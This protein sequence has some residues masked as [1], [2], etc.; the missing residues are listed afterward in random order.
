MTAPEQPRAELEHQ[1][2][3]A[4]TS[5]LSADVIV[6][7]RDV[8]GRAGGPASPRGGG[9]PTVQYPLG[10][11]YPG[12]RPTSPAC[13]SSSSTRPTRRWPAASVTTRAGLRWRS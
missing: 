12:S 11:W 4:S 2:H 5:R 6:D 8:H 13:G 9:T 7:E 1:P 3:T 10:E